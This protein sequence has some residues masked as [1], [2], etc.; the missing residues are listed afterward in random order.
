[1]LAYLHFQLHETPEMDK[2]DEI[3]VLLSIWCDW[4]T[5]KSTFHYEILE[6]SSTT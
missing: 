4:R 5:E 6:F 2:N 3:L 1:M